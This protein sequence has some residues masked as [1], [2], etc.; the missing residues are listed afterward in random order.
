M[1]LRGI[2]EQVRRPLV[3]ITADEPV[4]ILE[5]YAG[6]PLV[7]R[8]DRAGLEGRCIMVLPEPR[9]GK[10]VVQED[11]ANGSLVLG[12][13]AV[14]AGEARGLLGDHAE[15]GRVMIAP[16]DESRARRRTKRGG[17]NV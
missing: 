16:G 6:R 17:V 1:D 11:P 10:P 14:V 12:D 2:A 4:E 7:K 3:R 13:D 15:A 5:A 8:S 9:G